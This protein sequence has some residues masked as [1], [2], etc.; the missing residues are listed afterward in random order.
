[1]LFHEIEYFFHIKIYILF[2]ETRMLFHEIEYEQNLYEFKKICPSLKKIVPNKTIIKT[3]I[4][5]INKH[6]YKDRVF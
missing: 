3:I 6:S 4:K 2:R 5:T 1:M